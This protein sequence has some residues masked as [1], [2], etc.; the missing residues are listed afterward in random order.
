MDF[1]KAYD[2]VPMNP[3][4]LYKLRAY[5]ICGK[6]YNLI[7]S[8]PSMTDRIEVYEW[9]IFVPPKYPSREKRST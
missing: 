4:L 9:D 7:L 1:K 2:M 3:A 5:G 8:E 6:T